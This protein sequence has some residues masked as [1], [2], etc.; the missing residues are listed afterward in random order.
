MPKAQVQGAAQERQE[1]D[2]EA[3]PNDSTALHMPLQSLAKAQRQRRP[4]VCRHTAGQAVSPSLNQCA[5][6]LTL[7]APPCEPHIVDGSCRNL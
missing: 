7:Q 4:E 2:A 5:A 6:R 3:G 1:K